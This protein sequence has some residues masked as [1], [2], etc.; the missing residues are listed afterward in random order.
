M[1]CGVEGSGG[2]III[3]AA[4]DCAA[5]RV[6]RCAVILKTSK[7]I[8]LALHRSACSHAELRALIDVRAALSLSSV[9]Q[10]NGNVDILLNHRYLFY[11]IYSVW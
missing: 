11:A 2:K 4:H 10:V 7:S 9:V 3:D 5:S 6:K 8:V 1:R